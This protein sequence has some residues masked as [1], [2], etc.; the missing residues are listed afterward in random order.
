MK[1]LPRFVSPETR[2]VSTRRDTTPR[3]SLRRLACFL[4]A[5]VL[6]LT[7]SAATTDPVGVLRLK[8][9]GNSDTL[10]SLPLHRPALIEARLA[11]R[12]GNALTLDADVPSL[13]AEGAFALV[14][15]GPLEG[16]V[17]PIANQ[18][19]NTLT[20][21]NTSYDLSTLA[22]GPTGTL[23]AVIPYWTLDTAF[24]HGAGVHA[25]TSVLT[26]KSRVLL[27]EPDAIG[28]NNA[29]AQTFI[30]FAGNA[31]KSA[32]WYRSGDMSS[33]RGDERLLP[34]SHFIVRH[35]AAPDTDLMLHGSVQMSASR[36]PL[37]TLE[38]GRA[39]DNRTASPVP[40]P[41]TLA[42]SDLIASGAFTPTTNV[43]FPKDLL[44]VF[45]NQL[46]Q[47]NK[48]PSAVFIYF[49]G[50]GTPADGWYRTGNMSE[51]ANTFELKPG[52]GIIIRKRETDTPE[53]HHWKQ[54]PTYLQ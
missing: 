29:P 12:T 5:V 39:Q 15:T 23:L 1:L 38:A 28:V 53:L 40:V 34:H 16:A 46:V 8:L 17:L 49:D 50:N 7:V 37:G 36:Q 21:D 35:P 48:A 9:R 20:I 27:F 44:L 47:Q 19:D 42:A 11:E 24:P 3:V 32:G 43:L 2:P 52:E 26:P 41:I 54:S 31:T 30:Y 4:A 6:P 51:S 13:P 45:D 25:T 33:P 18:N 22:P 10:V 14:M